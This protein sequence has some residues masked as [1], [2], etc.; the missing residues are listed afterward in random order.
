MTSI[1][2]AFAE[3]LSTVR[4]PSAFHVAGTEQILAPGLTVEGVGPVAL[5]LLPIQAEQLIAAAERAPYGRGA[6]TLTD[7]GVRRT[8]QIAPERVRIAGKHWPATIQAIVT[9]V[10][11][12]LGVTDPVEAD[13]YK[14]LIYD[15]GSFFVPHRDTE[16]V[17]G[18]FA[19]LVL[20]LPSVSEG[21]ELIVRHKDQEVSLPLH[22]PEPSDVAFAAFYAD[23]VHEVRPVTAGYRLVLVYNLVRRGR[24]RLPS[25]PDYASQEDEVV[26]ALEQWTEALRSPGNGMPE[27][28]E[29]GSDEPEKLIFPLEHA[30]TPAELGFGSLKGAD[31]GIAQVVVAAASR[32]NCDVHLALIAIEESGIAEYNGDYRR[33]RRGRYSDEVDDEDGD[34]FEVVEMSDREAIASDWRRPDGDPSP[35]NDIPVEEAEF[36]PPLSFDDLEPDEQH[37]HEATGN[38]GASYERTYRRAALILWPRERLLAVI[39]QGGLTDVGKP[40]ATPPSGTRQACCRST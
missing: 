8:W 38:E 4:R 24:G 30:Y 16:K 23:C 37:F 40:L 5:P 15:Q 36:S 34:N 27:N 7:I 22:C 25:A 10:A 19:T 39:N 2:A 9:R 33:S 28:D 6:D 18:M 1:T 12:G 26:T 32:A 13:L 35:L 17:P 3:A 20:V 29:P 31:A 21:G 11:E 14:L